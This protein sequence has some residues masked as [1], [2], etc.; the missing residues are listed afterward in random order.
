M[1]ILVINS[2]AEPQDAAAADVISGRIGDLVNRARFMNTPIAHLHQK[3]SERASG[4][5][6]PI[7]RYEPVFQTDDI[8]AS[9]PDEF[10]DFVVNSTT[11]TV[12]L[13]GAASQEQIKRLERF[14]CAAGYS[15]QIEPATFVETRHQV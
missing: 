2:F 13:V 11:N 15:A 3:R 12:K 7:G 1:A 5:R 9:L 4:I 8:Q 14:F 10:I 6:I